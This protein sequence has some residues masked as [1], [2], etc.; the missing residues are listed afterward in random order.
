MLPSLKDLFGGG[1]GEGETD[2]VEELMRELHG[3]LS[4]GNYKGAAESMRAAH[5]VIRN[6]RSSA[7][8]EDGLYD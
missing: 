6:E 3:H 1:A 2:E 5:S 4:T 7:R 8:D